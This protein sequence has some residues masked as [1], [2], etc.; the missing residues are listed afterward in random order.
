MNRY[1]ED[2]YLSISNSYNLTFLSK[3]KGFIHRPNDYEL[4]EL[5][6]IGKK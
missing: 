4:A 6:L 1:F 3:E 5:N 2:I